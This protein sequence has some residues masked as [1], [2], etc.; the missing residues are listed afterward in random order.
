MEFLPYSSP[1]IGIPRKILDKAFIWLI[2]CEN[3]SYNEQS[4]SLFEIISSPQFNR[5]YR[6]RIWY[7]WKLSTTLFLLS[8]F[9]SF[10]PYISWARLFNCALT[11]EFLPNCFLII[12]SLTSYFSQSFLYTTARHSQ[13]SKFYIQILFLLTYSRRSILINHDIC[14]D[15]FSVFCRISCVSGKTST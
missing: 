7:L 12:R 2:L 1:L 13:F 10:F 15:A 9:H 14:L 5:S 6:L 3:S 11:Y 4:W 8:S